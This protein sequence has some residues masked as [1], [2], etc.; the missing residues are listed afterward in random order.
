M[1]RRRA[2]G[3]W[4]S[5][6]AKRLMTFAGV[7]DVDRAIDK[8]VVDILEGVAH[9]PTDLD[10]V[11]HRLKVAR[12]EANN[13][14]MVTGALRKVGSELSIHVF[15]GLSTGRRRF[16]IAHE[17]GHAFF[18]STGPRPPRSGKELETICDKF[19]AEVL[20]PRRSFVRCAGRRPD[21][22]R[23]FELAHIFRV[24]RSA[25][26]LRALDLY[27]FKSFEIEGEYFNWC[28]GL[29]NHEKAQL[30]SSFDGR[31]DCSGV[32]E[33]HLFGGRGHSVWN[34]EWHSME[35]RT[36]VIGLLTPF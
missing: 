1:L 34:M 9:P 4:T 7:A 29:W 30:L 12:V 32:E 10:G 31:R 2:A 16:T 24:S 19:A 22:G 20:M 14:M 3:R 8:V 11:M 17:L 27:R 21:I 35:D 33:I 5:A 6:A 25:V 15:P 18:E 28:F 13:D 36:R 23:L 26:F